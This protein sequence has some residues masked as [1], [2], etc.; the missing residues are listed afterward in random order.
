M[1]T[2]LKNIIQNGIVLFPKEKEN[3]YVTYNYNG[4][5]E[6]LHDE[7]KGNIVSIMYQQPADNP[8]NIIGTVIAIGGTGGGFYGPA[9]VYDLMADHLVNSKL[10]FLRINVHPNYKEGSKN[11]IIGINFLKYINVNSPVILMG[12]SMGGA[13]I[14]NAAS[15]VI[16]NNL[17]NIKSLIILAGQSAG[18]QKIANLKIP[19]YFLHGTADTCL[20]INVGKQVFE[21]AHEPKKFIELNGASHWMIEQQGLLFELICKWIC[22]S[23]I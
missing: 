20:P 7:Y 1:C 4:D 10:S 19:T 16:E 21:W 23:F 6:Y 3:G 18:A 9:Y 14:I 8:E 2:Q 5:I 13:S 15:D 11:V 22:E 12:W 17:I